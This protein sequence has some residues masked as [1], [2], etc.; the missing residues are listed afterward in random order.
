MDEGRLG[1]AQLQARVV[2]MGHAVLGSADP[3]G[4]QADHDVVGDQGIVD[5]GVGPRVSEVSTGGRSEFLLCR[6]KIVAVERCSTWRIS[7]ADI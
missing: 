5:D 1:Q 2:Q 7:W 6:M 3:V 4:Q